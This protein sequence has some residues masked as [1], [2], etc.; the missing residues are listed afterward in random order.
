[1]KSWQ[2]EG[3]SLDDKYEIEEY[4]TMMKSFADAATQ[5]DL[6]QVITTSNIIVVA[7]LGRF[8]FGIFA[9][10]PIL[11]VWAKLMAHILA[12]INNISTNIDCDVRGGA[13][14]GG[15]GGDQLSGRA[16]DGL[17]RAPPRRGRGP[18][19]RGDAAAGARR[20]Q[21]P[22]RPR[23]LRTHAPPHGRGQGGSVDGT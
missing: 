14:S 19:R 21:G 18:L 4:A 12:H 8:Y 23:L 16:L 9:S 3:L 13:G 10:L 20:G 1:M 15:G 2:A 5:G 7:S 22:A 11:I 6:E 17:D